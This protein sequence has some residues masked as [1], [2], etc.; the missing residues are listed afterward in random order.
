MPGVKKTLSP[1]G[2]TDRF[3]LAGIFRLATAKRLPWLFA[4][5]TRG[6]A[7]NDSF[8]SRIARRG[9]VGKRRAS[10][11]IARWVSK[12]PDNSVSKISTA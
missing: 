12:Q 6:G 10:L 9:S 3:V 8:V 2:Q 5:I 11:R 7:F 4:E 1:K